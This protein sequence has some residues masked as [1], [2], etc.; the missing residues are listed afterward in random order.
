[1]S[2]ATDLVQQLFGHKRGRGSI[3]RP[4]SLGGIPIALILVVVAA[5]WGVPG[6]LIRMAGIDPPKAMDDMAPTRSTIARS[7]SIP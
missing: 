7:G 6:V 4:P 2:D 3:P 1:M 5:L